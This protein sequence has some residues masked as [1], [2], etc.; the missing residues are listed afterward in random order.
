MADERSLETLMEAFVQGDQGAFVLLFQRLSPR[1]CG[2]LASLSGNR[3]LAEDLTQTT[4]LK[5]HRA[6][7]TFALGARVEPW[8][9]AIARRTLIDERRRRQRRPEDLSNDGTVPEPTPMAE[10]PE[11][12]RLDDDQE[13]ALYERLQALPDNQREAIVLLKVQGL[14]MQEAARIAGTTPG[15]MK[16]R[17]HRAYEALRA[18]IGQPTAVERARAREEAK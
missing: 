2:L 3:V 5:I 10:V 12:S 4:F 6:R 18:A 1:V 7:D 8:V 15:A 14:G 11:D 13:R 16:L 9:F 17:A